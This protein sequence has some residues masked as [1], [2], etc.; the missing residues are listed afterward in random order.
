MWRLPGLIVVCCIGCSAQQTVRGPEGDCG[1]SKLHP[2]QLPHYVESSALTKV[3][4]QYPPAAKRNGVTGS[5][6]VR[7]LINKQGL[8]ERTCPEY[9]RGE[10][11]PDRSLIVTAEAT[12]LQWTFVPNFGV[13]PV[14]GVRFT[15]VVDVLVFNFTLD[16]PG[17]GIAKPK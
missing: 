9:V 5:V 12:A 15:H 2:Q 10:P 3:T 6:R 13:Q 14:G 4:P 16:E 7:V 1:F 11:R 8:V 17:K